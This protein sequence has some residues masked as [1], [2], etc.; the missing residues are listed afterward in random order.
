MGLIC[1]GQT[2]AHG[3]FWH[4]ATSNA[5]G[6][7]ASPQCQRHCLDSNMER[8]THGAY[9][10]M[11]VKLLPECWRNLNAVRE[12]ERSLHF[13]G[14][15]E[16]YQSKTKLPQGLKSRESIYDPTK[17]HYFVIKSNLHCSE[18][19]WNPV[20]LTGGK[21]FPCCRTT[22]PILSNY[23][24]WSILSPFWEHEERVIFFNNATRHINV[25]DNYSFYVIGIYVFGAEMPIWGCKLVADVE[26]METRH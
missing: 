25:C 15:I 2:S 20:M 11:G 26:E 22:I 19:P 3:Q 21:L 17:R 1:L 24:L 6:F 5:S 10:C 18:R 12:N 7:Q 9:M 23:C 8:Q 4:T 13:E 14:V 16:C